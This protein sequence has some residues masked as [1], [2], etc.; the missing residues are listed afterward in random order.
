MMNPKQVKEAMMR[1][2]N[3]GEGGGGDVF[4]LPKDSIAALE[5]RIA[6]LE[7]IQNNKEAGY[8]TGSE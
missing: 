5:L 3:G 6:K 1:I 7:T 4:K 2:C 8:E